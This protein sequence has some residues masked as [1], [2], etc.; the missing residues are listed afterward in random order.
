[1]AKKPDETRMEAWKAFLRSY[2]AVIDALGEELR[3]EHDLPLSRYDVLV[4]LDS[5]DDRRMR[6][7]ELAASVLLTPSGLTRLVDRLEA[8]GLVRREQCASDRR[9]AHVVLTAEGRSRL[10]KAAPTHLRGIEEH[11][12]RHLTTDEADTLRRA[13][14]KVLS[15]PS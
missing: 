9:G 3:Q 7:N 2:R 1:M 4:Q 13:L 12:A 15:A 6:M 11:F 14:T 5:A 10:R 8:E